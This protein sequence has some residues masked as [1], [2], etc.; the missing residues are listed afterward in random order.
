MI[1]FG[2]V[3]VFDTRDTGRLDRIGY[4]L[5]PAHGVGDDL[6]LDV[7]L[8]H[9]FQAQGDICPAPDDILHIFYTITCRFSRKIGNSIV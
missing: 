5:C 3:F 4:E 9:L 1:M 2:K 8:V 7:V 6:P